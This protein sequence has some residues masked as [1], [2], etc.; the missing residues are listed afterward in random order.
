M[1]GNIK[2][3]FKREE[4]ADNYI[5]LKKMGE[6]NKAELREGMTMGIEE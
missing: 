1:M 3:G 6:G 4:P 2:G 5:E